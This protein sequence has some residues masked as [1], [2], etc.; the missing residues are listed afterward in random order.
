[1]ALIL[2]LV[3]CLSLVA[4]PVTLNMVS[5]GGKTAIAALDVCNASKTFLSA[6]E[7]PL[8]YPMAYDYTAVVSA[9][10]FV[11]YS[12]RIAATPFSFTKDQPPKSV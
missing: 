8:V 2:A 5:N 9:D 10:S 1:M 7:L 3:M 12:E 6:A 11:P 4:P